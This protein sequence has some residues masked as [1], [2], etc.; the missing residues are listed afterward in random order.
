MTPQ[1]YRRCFHCLSDPTMRRLLHCVCCLLAW[2]GLM[3]VSGWMGPMQLRVRSGCATCP[4][5]S[6]QSTLLDIGTATFRPRP[7]PQRRHGHVQLSAIAN[8]ANAINDVNN[9]EADSVVVYTPVWD[10]SNASVTSNQMDRLDDAIMG[11]I[12]TSAIRT[13]PGESFARWSGVCRTD[14]G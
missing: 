5:R 3:V 11:G 8:T 14:G 12:S 6:S 9:N 2:N 13:V 7:V 10:F 1:F 4:G